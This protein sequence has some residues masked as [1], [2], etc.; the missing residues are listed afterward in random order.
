MG[1]RRIS[2]G[3]QCE[4][5]GL[6]RSSLYYQERGE[7]E[8]NLKLLRLLDE[9]YTRTPFYGVPR[10]TAWLCRQGEQ[11]NEKR[12]RRLLR[13][14][15]LAAIY[16]QPRLSEAAPGHKIYPYLLR[17]V[18]ITRVNQVWSTD[19]T[20]IRLRQGFIY[21]VA[22]I[23]WFSRYVLSWEV[24]VTLEASFCLTA[25]IGRCGRAGQR[26]STRIRGRSLPATISPDDCWPRAF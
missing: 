19:I 25:L 12:V 23:D 11:V 16:P 26:S 17:N 18:A 7:N 22:V 24:S 2:L 20:Y 10:M 14:L 15:G 1:Q 6:A 13:L 9:Q 21:L 8:R 4:L 3:R 5:L